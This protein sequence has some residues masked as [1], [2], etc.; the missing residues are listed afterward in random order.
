MKSLP[1]P[2]PMHPGDAQK[3]P[4]GLHVLGVLAE[5]PPVGDYRQSFNF[6][7]FLS[8]YVQRNVNARQRGADPHHRKQKENMA[9]WS[10]FKRKFEEPQPGVYSAVIVDSE[11]KVNVPTYDGTGFVNQVNLTLFLDAYNKDGY[12]FRMWKTMTISN[13]KK[14]SL[15]LMQSALGLDTSDSEELVGVQ[16]RV[17]VSPKEQG[18]GVKIASFLPATERVKVPTTFVR[19][20]DKSPAAP[21]THAAPATPAAPTTKAS[22]LERF[23][24]LP[25]AVNQSPAPGIP[26]P[27]QDELPPDWVSESVDDYIEL[28]ED[29][30]QY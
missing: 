25:S 10:N 8:D 26:K 28:H 15:S 16:C 1:M 20:K 18:E 29:E 9:N 17:V 14:S 2:L 7:R 27:A 4:Q 22:S 5:G 24:D 13:H 19:S 30:S 12:Q 3:Q 21:A 6:F 23:R 11:I